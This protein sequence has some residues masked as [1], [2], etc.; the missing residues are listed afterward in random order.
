MKKID[1][2]NLEVSINDLL[3]EYGDMVYHGTEKGLDAAEKVLIN[4]LKSASPVGET[5]K[6]AKSWKSKGKKY[7]LKRY[8]GNTKMVEGKSGKIPLSN[9]LEYSTTR[10]KPFIKRTYE[11]SMNTMIAA[12]IAAIKKEA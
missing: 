10:G 7:K 9:I 11:N 2:G 5:G 3:S 8:V 6:F 4:N 12:V 1:I